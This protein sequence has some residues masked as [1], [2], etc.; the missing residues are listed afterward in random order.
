[1]SSDDSFLHKRRMGARGSIIPMH[2]AL[3]V[4]HLNPSS[5]RAI[6]LLPIAFDV[7]LWF[8]LDP[9]LR[10]WS[11][12]FR[13]FIT[14][15]GLH[16]RVFTLG[17]E[18]P[19][20]I[21]DM[22]FPALPVS[23]PSVSAVWINLLVCIAG[24]FLSRLIRN[25]FMPL[26]FLLRFILV[27]QASASL[28]FFISPHS[29]PYSLGTYITQCLTLGVYLLLLTPLILAMI[30][31][32][33]DVAFWCK[34][35][36]TALILVYFIIALPFQYMLHAM[37][38]SYGSLLFMPMLYIM[39]SFLLNTFIFICFYSWGMTWKTT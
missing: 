31:Y 18:M 4:V 1:M 25:R 5:R 38:I 19:W 13:F 15:L 32:I 11:S 36:L 14:H 12:M 8:C 7:V 30:Y 33:F 2:H 17:V 37:I 26:A 27:I 34:P 39:C 35:A 28:Y 3:R 9:I 6:V 16:G 24:F 21:I 20:G 22:P 10:L 29:F 23:L